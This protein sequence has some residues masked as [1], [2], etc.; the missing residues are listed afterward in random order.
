LLL[1]GITTVS[2]QSP[3]HEI[4]SL[5]ELE[6]LVATTHQVIA[7]LSVTGMVCAIESESRLVA[8]QDDSSAVLLE[9][10]QL[11]PVVQT[12]DLLR[13]EAAQIMLAAS[14][15]GVRIG[16]APVVEIDDLHPSVE[17]SGHV[18][19]AAGWQPVRLEWFNGAQ[20]GEV[21]VSYEGPGVSLQPIPDSALRCRTPATS[22]A[23]AAP[24]LAF[25]AYRGTNW[26]RLPDFQML[27]PVTNGVVTNFDVGERSQIEQVAMLFRGELLITTPGLYTFHLRTDDGGRLFVGTPST[28]VTA[29]ILERHLPP[30]SPKTLGQALEDTRRHEWTSLEGNVTFASQRGNQ[31]ELEVANRDQLYSVLM[32]SSSRLR[33]PLLVN[34][35]VQAT[36]IC[37]WHLESRIPRVIVLGAEQLKITDHSAIPSTDELITTASQ[38]RGLQP[39]EARRRLP[40]VIRGVVTTAGYRSCVV[41]DSTGPAFVS[42]PNGTWPHQPMVG[43]LWEFEGVTDPGDFSPIL[44]TAR[45]R[46]LGKHVLPPP[47]HPSWEQL[48]NGSMDVELIEVPGIVLD[49]TPD[50]LTLLTHGGRVSIVPNYE[51]PLPYDTAVTAPHQSLRGSRVTVRGVFFAYWESGERQLIPGRFLLGD[52]MISVEE[53]MPEDLFAVPARRVT[54]LLRFTTHADVLTRFKVAGQVLYARPQELFMADGADGFRVKTSEAVSLAEGDLIEAVGFPQLN[55]PSPVLLEAVA[56]KTGAAALP[57]ARPVS[58]SELFLKKN[59]STL[60]LVDAMLLSDITRL[61]ERVL[62]LQAGPHHFLARLQTDGRPAARLRTGAE[63]QLTGVYSS[64]LDGAPEGGLGSFELLLNSPSD[65]VVLKAGPWW[66]TRYTIMTFAILFLGLALSL[67]WVTLLRRT[68]AHRTALLEKEIHE[69][70]QIEQRRL[71]E[72]ER[73]RVAHDLHDEL[74]A[75][76]AQISLIGSLAQR[77]TTQAERARGLVAQIT[78]RS[79]EMVAALDEIVWAINPTHDNASSVRGYLS[80][81]AQEFLH[82]TGMACRLDIDSIHSEQALNSTQRHQLFLAFKEALTNVVKH[83]KASE[84]WIRISTASDGLRI[85]VEDNGR[86]IATP[87]EVPGGHG[88]GSMRARLAQ[89]GGCC[90]IQ[91]RPDGG[92]IVSFHLPLNR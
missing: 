15:A 43:E 56:R 85:S 38:V 45:S 70:E 83:A 86:G 62:E 77:P 89:V 37:Q 71:L 50:E 2:A 73:A 66:T 60:V 69:R 90:E 25:A 3:A 84:V 58:A 74:G 23:T 19:L 5:A 11:D 4:N 59:D 92:T 87:A 12:G 39:E 14:Q 46:C 29:T 79:R 72:Q 82:P 20:T 32:A 30:P 21:G 22:G 54:D 48:N 7:S 61:G 27:T 44:V 63:L 49:A 64:H 16:T 88:T 31:I 47:I 41:Q 6:D 24:G 42:Y 13:V 78:T 68:V 80:E 33:T 26:T 67:V 34:Q 18:Y 9:L 52:G 10:P 36:G 8:L 40:A 75:G 17:R 81:Y 51:Y 1:T 91:P 57:V 53:P 55:G 35:R 65:I 28:Q 76:L